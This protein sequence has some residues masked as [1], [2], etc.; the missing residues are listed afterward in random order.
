MDYYKD[1]VGSQYYNEEVA[2]KGAE[3]LKNKGY[4]NLTHRDYMHY[5]GIG[6]NVLDNLTPQQIENL[7]YYGKYDR[8]K[9]NWDD[10]VDTDDYEGAV[11]TA[12]TLGLLDKP[13]PK[14][15]SLGSTI[16]HGLSHDFSD[17]I[18]DYAPHGYKWKDAEKLSDEQLEELFKYHP[19]ILAGEEPWRRSADDYEGYEPE[20]EEEI[21]E[22]INQWPVK[23]RY[24]KFLNLE[25]DWAKKEEERRKPFVEAM[26]KEVKRE[27]YPTFIDYIHAQRRYFKEHPEVEY[28]SPPKG[29]YVGQF[30][31]GSIISHGLSHDFGEMEQESH[32]GPNVKYKIC[33]DKNG[34]PFK[35]EFSEIV[36]NIMSL[37]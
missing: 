34:E 3:N 27:D 16:S 35:V 20:T 15:F 30:S 25:N 18:F 17:D 32:E 29:Y 31:I 28:Q 22:R 14:S 12:I 2:K 37:I 6:D 5:W 1:S 33:H 9:G 7:K 26:N 4:K 8:F 13:L 21:Q 23:G 11:Q 19:D 36:N 10:L 24:D